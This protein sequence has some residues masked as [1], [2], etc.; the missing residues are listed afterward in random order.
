MRKYR[1]QHNLQDNTY[2]IERGLRFL[3]WAMWIDHYYHHNEYWV[4]WGEY[5][6]HEFKTLEEAEKVFRDVIK[7][8]KVQYMTVMKYP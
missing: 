8:R 7:S 6:A 5:D 3:P 1:I 4:C 2:T